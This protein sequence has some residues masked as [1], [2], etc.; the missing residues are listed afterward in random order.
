MEKWTPFNNSIPLALL[1]EDQVERLKAAAES[2]GVM[3]L[4]SGKVGD[5]PLWRTIDN[6]TWKLSSTCTYRARSVPV[7]DWS[8][9]HPDIEWIAM[10][11]DGRIYG[12]PDRPTIGVYSFINSK[13][14]AYVSLGTALDPSVL[15]FSGIDWKETLTQ[16]PK[17]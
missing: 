13:S 17:A 9:I 12:Y 2:H 11:E 4:Q 1:T 10:D 3:A 8:I 5:E 6:P 14:S 16:R 7:I 15:N